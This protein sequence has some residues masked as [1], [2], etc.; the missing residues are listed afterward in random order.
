MK[1]ILE[2]FLSY[3]LIDNIDGNDERYAKI[4]QATKKLAE[5]F[6]EEPSILVRAIISGL[7]P[8]VA[9]SDENICKAKEC[10]QDEWKAYST[11][12]TDEPINLFRGMILEA[13]SMV[14]NEGYN[15]AIMWLVSSDVLPLFELGKEGELLREFMTSLAY[16]AENSCIPE[17]K[18]VKLQKEKVIKIGNIEGL[19]ESKSVKV[20]RNDLRERIGDAAGNTHIDK[21][22]ANTNKGN[23]NRYWP[24]NHPAQWAGDFAERMSDAIADVCDE[25]SLNSAKNNKALNEAILEYAVELKNKLENSLNEQRLNTQRHLKET[26]TVQTQEQTRL[27]VLW[28]S[29]ALYSKS[30]NSS[31]RE[32]SD[33]VATTLMPFDLLNE[34][35]VPVSSSVGYM[36]SETVNKLEGADFQKKVSFY[37]FL[38]AIRNDKAHI[39]P[40]C[41]ENLS[42]PASGEQLNIIDLVTIAVTKDSCDLNSLIKSSIVPENWEC[43]LPTL[44]RIIFKQ[45]QAYEIVKEGE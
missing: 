16:Q 24:H 8:S 40:S 41:L 31:Y 23:P 10:L 2:S 1:S 15:A 13:C 12:Y 7:N 19:P 34:I 42:L 11:A 30:L 21:D 5:R 44:S 35:S 27:N 45:A 3:G 36:L 9:L 20:K 29:E 43:S 17:D 38:S 25:V 22:G 33:E 32:F 37:E 26:L 39:S 18:L 14:A 6:Q 28:W 4:E